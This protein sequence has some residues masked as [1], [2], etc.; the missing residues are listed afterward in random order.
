MNIAIIINPGSGM[1]EPVIRPINH[2]MRAIGAR[3]EA[4]ITHQAG[5]AFRYAQD[6]VKEGFDVVCVYG[7]DDTVI[8][9]ARALFQSK[10]PL[11]VLPGGSANV[12]AK[13]LGIPLQI[14]EA[15]QH[16]QPTAKTKEIDMF[17]CDKLPCLIRVNIGVFADMI[18]KTERSKKELLGQVAYGVSMIQ[19]IGSAENATYTLTIDGRPKTVSG[20][21]LVIA[22]S[23][24]IG[25]PGISYST[26]MSLSDHKLDLILLQDAS[27]ASISSFAGSVL[28]QNE[29][30]Q[31][32]Q[33][34]A[35]RLTLQIDPPQ[36]VMIDDSFI[37]T[38]TR[39]QMSLEIVPKALTILLPDAT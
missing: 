2:H 6:A 10:V 32:L 15:L 19:E 7:G 29:D 22:N 5:D 24:N 26:K 23:G 9:T 25:I 28:F 36:S 30:S 34:Q 8:E 17:L 37:T 31:L 12:F 35:E 16:I 27:L 13:D 3:W 4:F 20:V 14:Q 38:E 33:L 11:A 39:H 1:E 21:G 18:K